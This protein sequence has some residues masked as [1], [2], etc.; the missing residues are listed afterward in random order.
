MPGAEILPFPDNG[1]A[2]LS[3][4]LARLDAALQEQAAAVRGFRAAVF[5]LKAEVGR[6][7]DGLQGYRASLE[8]TAGSLMA[9]RAV[10][11]TLDRTAD[12]LAAVCR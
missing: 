6:L 11:R 10:L 2:R 12:G 4:A 1:P 3:R 5:D 9:T 8:D 7:E